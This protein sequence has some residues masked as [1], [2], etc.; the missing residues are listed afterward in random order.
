MNLHEDERISSRMYNIFRKIQKESY[1]KGFELG[2]A[3]GRKV[4][5]ECGEKRTMEAM[6]FIFF[7]SYLKDGMSEKEAYKKISDICE[8]PLDY[9]NRAIFNARLYCYEL[10]RGKDNLDPHEDECISSHMYNICKNIQTEILKGE[11]D[12]PVYNIFSRCLKDEMSEAKAYKVTAAIFGLFV[13]EVKQEVQEQR[14]L[15]EANQ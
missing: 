15:L 1:D 9:V 2:E 13:D 10:M 14:A 5:E 4:G 6:A 12:S 7:N 11:T 3:Y 8:L